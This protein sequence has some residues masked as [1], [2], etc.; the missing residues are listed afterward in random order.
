M[1]DTVISGGNTCSAFSLK[2]FSHTKLFPE[3]E[4]HIYVANRITFNGGTNITQSPRL[5]IRRESI[6]RRLIQV[7]QVEKRALGL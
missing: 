3:L 2:E 4:M 6:G 7:S 1:P 5:R